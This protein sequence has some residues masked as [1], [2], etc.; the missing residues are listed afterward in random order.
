MD[1]TKLKYI[2]I[3]TGMAEISFALVNIARGDY[4]RAIFDSG[5]AGAAFM[6]YYL[7]DI[8]EKEEKIRKKFL[9]RM[10]RYDDEM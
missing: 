10:R 2:N 4:G 7:M 6:L 9:E 1:M 8:N 3:A 5:I